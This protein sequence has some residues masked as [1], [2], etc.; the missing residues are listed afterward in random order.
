MTKVFREKLIISQRVSHRLHKGP[1]QTP[2]WGSG[3]R[4][5]S[6]HIA[7]AYSEG[8]WLI[9]FMVTNCLYF[10]RPLLPSQTFPY[11]PT[12]LPFLFGLQFSYICFLFAHPSIFLANNRILL[13]VYLFQFSF[14][15]VLLIF[16]SVFSFLCHSSFW[17]WFFIFSFFLRPF[18]I[19]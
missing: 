18:F 13:F 14:F 17:F 12:V 7:D 5:T 19:F 10:S 8:A 15:C 1:Y 4:A 2:S 16:L 6:P 3:T 9:R 11:F